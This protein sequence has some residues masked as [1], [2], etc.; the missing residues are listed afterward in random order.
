[1]YNKKYT[2]GILRENDIPAGRRH[3]YHSISV[4]E[5]E[6]LGYTLYSGGAKG[7]DSAF[8][9]G[10][11]DSNHKQIFRATDATDETRAI[12]RFLHPLHS[13]L[14]GYALDLFAR[15]TNQVF[16]RYLDNVVDFEEGVSRAVLGKFTTETTAFNHCE[17][18]Y[19]SPAFY[20]A[21]DEEE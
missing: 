1:M 3:F 9:S 17:F 18:Y 14:S 10:V 15:N 20:F 8:E 11:I 13:K 6:K 5:L 16:G 21:Q 4:A 12:A 19:P 2:I 7:A